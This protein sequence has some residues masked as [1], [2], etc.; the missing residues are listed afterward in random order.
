MSTFHAD[1]DWWALLLLAA[2]ALV[3]FLSLKRLQWL[4]AI[5][6]FGGDL[7][8]EEEPTPHRPAPQQHTA[9]SSAGRFSLGKIVGLALLA[10]LLVWLIFFG[11]WTWLVGGGEHTRSIA[12]TRTVYRD[13]VAHPAL[14]PMEQAQVCAAIPMRT[15]TL[16]TDIKDVEWIPIPTGCT[17]MTDKEPYTGY[18]LSDCM[19]AGT[20]EPCGGTGDLIRFYKPPQTEERK[21]KVWLVAAIEK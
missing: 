11:G 18:F 5:G 8:D 9:G 6:K 2:L 17:V 12:T 16:Q 20:P 10:A 21:L 15:L 7:E 19:D 1:G 14:R 13:R 3:F 4:P